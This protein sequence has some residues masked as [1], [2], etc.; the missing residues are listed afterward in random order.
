MG[1]RGEQRERERESE[2]GEGEGEDEGLGCR[3]VLGAFRE[4]NFV[5]GESRAIER[6]SVGNSRNG[7]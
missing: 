4:A 5:G 7:G 6:E 1:G 3:C 2:R